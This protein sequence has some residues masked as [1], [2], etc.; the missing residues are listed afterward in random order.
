M[1]IYKYQVIPWVTTL[2][3]T[4][5]QPPMKIYK[6]KILPW[7]TTLMPK[8][9]QILAVG[10]QNND[11]VCWAMV[12]DTLP[13]VNRDILGLP[14]G[15][16]APPSWAVFLNTVQMHN[17]LVFHFFDCGENGYLPDHDTHE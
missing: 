11:I 16:E 10:E 15:G 1:K 7:V 4:E 5:K 9:A 12:D 2:M 14:T 6:Y 13:T 17:G 3:P 8:N